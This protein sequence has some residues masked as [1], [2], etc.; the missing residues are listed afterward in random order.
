MNKATNIAPNQVL[1]SRVTT[2][3]VLLSSEFQGTRRLAAIEAVSKFFLTMVV[4]AFVS[5]T[6]NAQFP[7]TGPVQ[8]VSNSEFNT[9]V[10][11]RQSVVSNPAVLAQQ[12]LQMLLT[13]FENQAIVDEFILENPDLPGVAAL[14]AATPTSP[15]VQPTSDGNYRMVVTNS[16]GT[17]ETIETMGQ[18]T[19]LAELANSIKTSSDP[20][21]Q[22]AL[23][24]MLYSQ[25]TNFYN[26]V[27][28]NPTGGPTSSP[29]GCANLTAPSALVVPSQLQ[30]ASLVIIQGALQSLASQG[31]NVYQIAPTLPLPGG[32]VACS[33][34]IG[35]STTPGVNS[36]YGFGDQTESS[37]A[38]AIS[39]N[40]IVANFG[41]PSKSLL[42]CIKNQG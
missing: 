37:A 41:F 9:M 33:Q 11:D 2:S 13:D 31:A 12:D 18:A 28:T 8:V 39:P 36:F 42:S 25:Y 19:K 16:Q 27:C 17:S 15:N 20:V 30:G 26:E 4:L 35:A 32:P 34:E 14:V 38:C 40:G 21:Q 7:S 6:A 10:K 3:S 22:L 1:L 24:G 23:Y 5:A 29:K